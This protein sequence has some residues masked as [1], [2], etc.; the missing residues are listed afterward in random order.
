MKTRIVELQKSVHFTDLRGFVNCFN[1]NAD[2]KRIVGIVR[3]VAVEVASA[4]FHAGASTPM[5]DKLLQL[6]EVHEG[7]V[8]NVSESLSLKHYRLG[9]ATLTTALRVGWMELAVVINSIP[10]IL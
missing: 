3:E 4:L 8:I 9:D 1:V 2:T 10:L 6:F 5:V 7:N